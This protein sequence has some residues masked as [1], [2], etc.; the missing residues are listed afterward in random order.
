MSKPA[1]F[2]F[3]CE[4]AD[5]PEAEQHTVYG[6]GELRRALPANL[7]PLFQ[8]VKQSPESLTVV[9]ELTRYQIRKYE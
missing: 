7:R 3:D 5:D 8:T 1:M 9:W 2:A 6:L 4:V